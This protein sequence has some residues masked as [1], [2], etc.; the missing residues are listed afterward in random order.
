M[1]TMLPVHY[2][3]GAMEEME[4]RMILKSDVDAV[5]RAYEE[6]GAA[7]FDQEHDWLVT[8][9]RLGNVTFWVKFRKEETGYLIF[10]AYRHRMTVE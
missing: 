6:S 5:L 7:V 8:S 9:H 3:Q 4:D 2:A 10:G 1:E